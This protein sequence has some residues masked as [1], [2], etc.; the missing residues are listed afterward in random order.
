MNILLTG[1]TGF[2]GSHTAVELITR[3]HKAVLYD[4]LCNSDAAVV[5][6]LEKITGKRPLLV[7][8]DIRD[9][10]KLQ[11]VLIAEKIDV[12]IHF[13]GLKAVGESCVKPLEYYDNNVGGT[14]SLLKAMHAAGVTRIIFSS[15][16]TVYGTP[17]YLPLTEEHPVGG[18]TNPY[19]R[20]KL[21]IEDI[22]KDVCAARPDFT[23]VC[24]RYFNPIGA[25]ASGLIGENPNGIPNNLLPYVA[26][27]A[28]GRLA[29]VGVFGNDYPTK[30]GTGVRDYIHVVDLARGHAL[31]CDKIENLKGWEAVTSVPAPVT[32]CLRS[33]TP[34]KRPAVIR[35]PMRSNRA[36][37][38]T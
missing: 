36:A 17:Q 25:H 34:L 31:T 14:V 29:R 32:A 22:L 26:R 20:T 19:G 11:A 6:A 10:E 30:D 18:V 16:S 37:R 5:D 9:T 7:V 3:G 23:A 27:V 4:N 33:F 8:G 15:S 12:V 35:S 28:S 13:A 1:G 24:L 21:F 38:A 2:I